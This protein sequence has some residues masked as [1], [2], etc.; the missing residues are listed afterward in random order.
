[1]RYGRRSSQ[2]SEEF[3]LENR[4]IGERMNAMKSMMTRILGTLLPVVVTV[5]L[6]FPSESDAEATHI[7]QNISSAAFIPCANGGAGESVIFSGTLHLVFD[8]ADGG[9]RANYSNVQG[10]GL[11]TGDSYVVMN[12]WSDLEGMWWIV[13]GLG[14][15]GANLL[16]LWPN[17]MGDP[18][19]HQCLSRDS[20]L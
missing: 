5:C 3:A 20:D 18:V 14:S 10:T 4:L 13:Q 6:V 2:I 8:V 12:V 19:V 11:I 17:Q 15:D 16:I 9:P 1:M 7:E